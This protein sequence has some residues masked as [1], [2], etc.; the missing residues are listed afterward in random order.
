MSSRA[1]EKARAREARM[2]A[3][4][5][6]EAQAVR[7]RRL[8]IFGGILA[9]AAAVLLVVVLVTSGGDDEGGSETA[10]RVALFDGIP[11]EGPW[12][13]RPDAPIVVEEYADLQCPFCA[14]FATE[15][16][17]GFV[18]DYVRTGKVRMRLRLLTFVG[19]ESVEAA[20][21]ASGT[22]DQNKLWPFTEAFYA[23]QGPENSGY[24]TEDF[25]RDAAQKAGADPDAAL[26]ARGTPAA[27]R[28][29]AEDRAAATK[30]RVNS[31][32]SFTVA[33]R[34]DEPELVQGDL[35]QAVDALAQP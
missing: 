11:Q 19:P 15:Q 26:N 29:I 27:E 31:T 8:M 1:E 14:A 35:R 32:P 4:A 21:V 34:G 23:E 16:L 12:L 13:G 18:E 17:P 28:Q 33:R 24:V 30:L 5:Q 2:A 3:E 7:R 6:A 25:L 10:E 20:E 22:R 9:V